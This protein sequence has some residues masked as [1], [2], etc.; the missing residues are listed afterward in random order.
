MDD[1]FDF[2]L[3]GGSLV[4]DNGF[5][6]IGDAAVA[7]STTTWNDTNHS[8]RVWGNDGTSFDAGLK[9]SGNAMVGPTI[10]QA[11]VNAAMT[12]G[13]LPVYLDLCAP[14]EIGAPAVLDFGQVT[15][16]SAAERVL[17]VWNAGDVALWG[18]AG[19]DSLRYTLSANAG[20]AAPAGVFSDAA[21]GTGNEHVI[22]MDTST[23]GMKTS[24]ITIASNAPDQPTLTVAL[25]G[26]VVAA[27]QPGDL[28]CDGA[29][30]FRDINPLVLALADPAGYATTF[31][32]CEWLNGDCNGDGTVDFRDINPF[33]ALLA[34]G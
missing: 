4:D 3:A 1:R 19:I 33:V 7:F 27:Y 12:G 17:T 10:A 30:D 21:G 2:V 28:N 6:Y 34:G 32:D 29:V 24:Q 18:A 13:H 31:P 9:T 5:D 16:G 14:A 22:T 20:F 26:E 11:L 15:Q 8:Y 23:L 25:A